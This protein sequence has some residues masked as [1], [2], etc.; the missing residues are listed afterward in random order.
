MGGN[1][2]TLPRQPLLTEEETQSLLAKARS[3]DEAARQQLA[4]S[5]LRLVYK[6]AQ[7]FAGRGRE[8]EDLFQVGSIGLIKAIDKFD[9]SFEVRFSTYAV[10]MIMGEI[11]RYLRDDNPLHISRSLKENAAK[12]LKIK[13][14]LVQSLGRE[15]TL[16]ELAAEADL[17]REEIILALDS[18]A[19]PLSLQDQIFGDEQ[20]P[21]LQDQ[22]EDASSSDEIWVQKLALQEA[23]NTLKERERLVLELRFFQ[24][25]T[26]SEAAEEIGISQA[27]V[28]RLEKGALDKMK[29]LI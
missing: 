15:P 19:E 13:E 9:P 14:G 1:P 10:P 12:L 2:E 29:D 18:L 24:A 16:E 3:G 23:I 5:H 25:K 7:R 6:V 27:Q 28:S 21:I 22:I 8:L 17:S 11:R 26:Q 20:S 4:A